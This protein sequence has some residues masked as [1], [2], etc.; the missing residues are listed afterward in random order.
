MPLNWIDVSNGSE[1]EAPLDYFLL[2][3]LRPWFVITSIG[4]GVPFGDPTD[5]LVIF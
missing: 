3:C 1:N 5:C 4:L 2:G